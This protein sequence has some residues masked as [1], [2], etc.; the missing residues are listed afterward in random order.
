MG[1]LRRTQRIDNGV[2]PF[3][4]RDRKSRRP[5]LADAVPKPNLVPDRFR[6]VFGCLTA[7]KGLASPYSYSCYT[8]RRNQQNENKDTGIINKN[9]TGG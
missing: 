8:L 5:E 3:C 2:A 7:P 4:E 6:L 1:R 9:Q